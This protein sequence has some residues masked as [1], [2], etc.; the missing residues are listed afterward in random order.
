M[1]ENPLNVIPFRPEPTEV[2]AAEQAVIGAALLDPTRIPAIAEILGDPGVFYR[3][4]HEAIWRTITRMRAAGHPVDPLLLTDVLHAQGDLNKVGGPGYLHTC[5]AATPTAA[6]GEYYA[7][8]VRAGAERRRINIATSRLAHMAGDQQADLSDVRTAAL[9]A[10]ADLAS[11]ETWLDPV[12]LGSHGALP[13][14]PVHALPDWVG[15]Y[16]DAVA[17]FTQTPPDMAATMALAALSTAAGGR[18][19]VEIRPGW[20]EQS[21][22]YLVCAMPPA[23]RKS[24]VFAFMTGPVY[25]VEDEL[26]AGAK[27]AIIE[28]QTAKETALA[29][30]EALMNKARKNPDLDRAHLVAEI[31]AARMVADDITVPPTPRLTMSG[32]LTPETVTHHLGVHRCLAALS[33]EGDLFDSIAGRYS[34]KPNL[35]VFLQA[36]KGERLQTDRITRE[37]PTVDKPALT[38]GVTPQPAVL[39]ELGAAPGARDRGLLARFLYSL[40]PSNLGYRKIRTTPVPAPVATTYDVRLTAL[41]HT[42]TALDEP[43]TVTMTEA[44]DLAVERLQERFEVQLR[45]DEPLAHIKDWAGKLVG[46][47]ARIATL[48]HLAD[49]IAGDWRAPVEPATVDRAAEIAEYFTAHTLAVFDLIAADPATDDAHALLQW[50]QRPRKDGTHRTHIKA[51]D[52]VASSRRFKKVADVEPA[53][54]LLEQHGWLRTD[55]P[56]ASGQRGRPQALTYRVHPVVSTPTGS[57]ATT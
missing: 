43:V 14:F 49:H 3:P 15:A 36:H 38:I 22:L 32:D 52:A 19:N 40:P 57:D 41:L 11:G 27:M 5:I 37:Q 45:P 18:V 29:E 16:V 24:D 47:I 33:P 6:N 1:T 12:P 25:R 50:L 56:P 10:L 13:T 20:R 53:L 54:Q 21:N 48:L 39:Q 8:L 23:S 31:T 30:V 28:A 46:H 2:L 4:A 7:D 17:E 42:L 9:A 34:S 55:Q 26:Q 51:H 44:A 35:G